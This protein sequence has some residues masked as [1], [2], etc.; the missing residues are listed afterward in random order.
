MILRGLYISF[1]DLGS[2]V[3]NPSGKLAL[4]TVVGNSFFVNTLLELRRRLRSPHVGK[5]DDLHSWPATEC[6][7]C[8]R[9]NAKVRWY[10]YCRDLIWR[11]GNALAQ[12]TRAGTHAKDGSS[13]E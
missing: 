4:E 6:C 13:Q 2:H 7:K 9:I 8:L 5:L 12:L 1:G 11:G 3:G 10:K